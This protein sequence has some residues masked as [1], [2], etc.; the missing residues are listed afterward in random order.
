MEA[1]SFVLRHKHNLQ[2]HGHDL[3]HNYRHITTKKSMFR[4]KMQN[5]KQ[6]TLDVN[7]YCYENSAIRQLL[8][9]P[10]NFMM[11]HIQYLFLIVQEICSIF[12]GLLIR[13]HW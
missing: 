5:Q 1:T 2:T 7:D 11:H 13:Y 3:E 9:R 8:L 6:F 4:F 10:L 12:H